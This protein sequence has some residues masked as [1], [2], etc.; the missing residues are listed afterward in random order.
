MKARKGIWIRNGYEIF[1]EFGIEGLKIERLAK[2]VGVQKSSFYHYF[3]DIELFVECLLEYHLE[4][5]HRIAIK[6]QG[7]KNI[8]PELIEILVEH[9][10]DLL[11]NRQLRINR[12]NE[13]FGTTLKSSDKIIGDAFVLVWIKDLNLQLTK[14]KLIAIFELAL[15]NF[16]LQ[17]NKENL[18][19]QWLSSYFDNLKRIARNIV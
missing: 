18:N 19:P 1:A 5:S 7:A 4:Q 10:T 2:K 3:A 13:K 12:Q 16:Y 15:E 17:I 8:D 11:F 9:K 6:E 14:P